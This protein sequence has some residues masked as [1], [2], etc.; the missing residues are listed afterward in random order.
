M[1][2]PGHSHGYRATR[3]VPLSFCTVCVFSFSCFQPSTCVCVEDMWGGKSERGERGE[4]GEG[5]FSVSLSLCS[6]LSLF[7][8]CAFS[9][10]SSLK[11]LSTL[12]KTSYFGLVILLECLRFILH[13][14]HLFLTFFWLDFCSLHKYDIKFGSLKENGYFLALTTLEKE[15]R[16]VVRRQHCGITRPSATKGQKKFT[17]HFMSLPQ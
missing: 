9:L 7:D 17:P 13:L 15:G 1:S 12:H 3:N 2:L 11:H 6:L 16:F 10:P 5:A 14:L 8:T 4:R